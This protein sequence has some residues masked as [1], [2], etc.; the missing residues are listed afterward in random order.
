MGCL[1]ELPTL[2]RSLNPSPRHIGHVNAQEARARIPAEHGQ[3]RDRVER[4][5]GGREDSPRPHGPLNPR[6]LRSKRVKKR[7]WTVST[8]WA[9]DSIVPASDRAGLGRYSG[10]RR[11]FRGSARFESHLGH[12]NPLCRGVFALTC[13]QG[14]WWRPSG[15]L[16]RGLWPGRRCG[17][18]RC[19]RA[20]SV[21]W[22]VGLPPALYWG[23]AVPRSDFVGL[24]GGG[25]HLFMVR[26]YES[27]MTCSD[28]AVWRHGTPL[29]PLATAICPICPVKECVD[30]V[31]T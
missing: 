21:P 12:A 2:C 31:H 27:Y 15:R 24:V 23:Y 28:L 11:I 20:G 3:C 13:V 4:R 26:G 5:W 22:L 6:G 7:V 9:S 18:F 30:N 10:E 16:V 8:P 14:W 29:G 25:Q 17:L 19:V 1:K